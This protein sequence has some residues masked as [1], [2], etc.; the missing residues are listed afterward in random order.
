LLIS[1]ILITLSLSEAK[2]KKKA[3]KESLFSIKTLNCLVC[4]F[5]VEEIEA[6]IFKVDPHKKVETGTWR[7]AGDGTQEGR[8][9]IP[10]ARSNEHLSEVVDSVCKGFEDYAQATSKAGGEPTLI[11]LMTH[12]GNMNPRMSEVDIV[13]DDDLNTR[14][15][16]YCENIVEDQEENILQLFAKE[17]KDM[18]IEL[19]SKRTSLCEA[20]EPA[21]E[22]YAF[23]ND[24]L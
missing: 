11:R 16:F 2:K 8:K 22:E 5:L 19:C 10:Y 20:E 1:I 9:T 23:E 18:D 15:K 3:K 14:L 7:L 17:G 12:Q 4:K 6:L 13:P 24:E 21:P